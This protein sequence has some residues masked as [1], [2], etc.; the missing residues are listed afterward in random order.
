MLTL[1]FRPSVASPKRSS[2]ESIIPWPWWISGSAASFMA[3]STFESS[4][5]GKGIEAEASDLS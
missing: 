3:V 2:M 4:M 5:V 1:T